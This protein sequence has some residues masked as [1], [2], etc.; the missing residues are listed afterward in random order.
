MSSAGSQL[1]TFLISFAQGFHRRIVTSLRFHDPDGLREIVN[2]AN[3][4]RTDSCC[5]R[6]TEVLSSG[7]YVDSYELER[8]FRDST[9][10]LRI[11]LYAPPNVESPTSISSQLWLELDASMDPDQLPSSVEVSLPIHLRYRAAVNT[12]RGQSQL[13]PTL[14]YP[15]VR[16]QIVCGSISDDLA[17]TQY[18]AENQVTAQGSTHSGQSWVFPIIR[19]WQPVGALDHLPIVSACTIGL[20]LAAMILITAAAWSDK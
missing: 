11:R 17:V 4:G 8:A 1:L 15:P 20:G 16:V 2:S 6:F 7:A 10:A 18:Y 14:I 5:L 3:P 9:P 19:V 13:Q 12:S